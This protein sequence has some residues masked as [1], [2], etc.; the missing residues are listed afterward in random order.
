M[1]AF[2]PRAYLLAT[3]SLSP[4]LLPPPPPAAG[5]DSLRGRVLRELGAP[6]R[7]LLTGTPL[8]N[9]LRELLA[10]LAFMADC[11]IEDIERRVKVRRVE[12]GDVEEAGPGRWSVVACT[13]GKPCAPS[14]ISFPP[15]KSS[16]PPAPFPFPAA[17]GRPQPAVAGGGIPGRGRRRG[18]AAGAGIHQVRFH[19]V[20]WQTLMLLGGA[21]RCWQ[22]P[23]GLG[24]C[25]LT[26]M[27]TADI[28][29]CVLLRVPAGSSLSAHRKLHAYLEPRMLRRMKAV[30]LAGQ[31]PPKVGAGCF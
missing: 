18:A 14:A 24:R 11:K 29:I 23:V 5:Q 21:G 16:C 10:L 30:C 2:S 28:I 20:D 6:W 25:W 4:A 22:A 8:Q 13:A 3:G 15:H 31:M 27:R 1:A 7:L 9:N 26:A 17:H 19:G 12:R